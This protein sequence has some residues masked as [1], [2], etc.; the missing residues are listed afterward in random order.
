MS[1][2]NTLIKDLALYE[3]PSPVHF[4]LPIIDGL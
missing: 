4:H 3:S 1:F 2:H